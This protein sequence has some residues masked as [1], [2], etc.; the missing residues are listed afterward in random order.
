MARIFSI[1]FYHDDCLQHALVS[2]H[3]KSLCIEYKITLL[4]QDILGYLP[5]NKIIY[6]AT[7]Q[8]IFSDVEANPEM[9]TDLMKEI[10]DAI[11]KHMHIPHYNLH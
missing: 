5:G 1:Q 4:D 11:A 6:T 2:V 3:E 9:Y 7:G 10:I 8:F